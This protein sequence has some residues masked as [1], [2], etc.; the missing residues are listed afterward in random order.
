MKRILCFIITLALITSTATV[1]FAKPAKH[2]DKNNKNYAEDQEFE[3]EDSKVIK[4]GR[5]LLPIDPIVKGMGA[6]VTFDKNTA[7]LTVKKDTTTLIIDFKNKKVT[8]NG[9]E[10]T[11]SGIFTAKNSKKRIVLIKYIAKA[12]GVRVKVD[13]DKVKI[14]VP[15]VEVPALEAPKN[16]KITPIGENVVANT[17]NSTTW[18]FNVTADIKAGQATGGKAELYVNSKLVASTAVAT[19]TGS[20]ISFTTSDGTPTNEE[21]RALVP[22]GGDVTIKLY[23]AENKVVQSTASTKLT[24][25]YVAPTLTSVTSAI[26]QETTGELYLVTVGAGN[27]G[28]AVDVTKLTLY[29]AALAKS[30]QLTNGEKGSKATIKSATSLVITLGEMDRLGIKGFGA[31]TLTLSISAGSLISDK[32]GNVSTPIVT[33]ITLP[34]IAIR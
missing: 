31:T 9:V 32:A 21:L 13:D 20:A 4:Y 30:Y 28:D 6:T 18:Y 26:Y 11:K 19:A 15:E 8:L 3:D 7:V 14:E 33:P 22:V 25:D 10:D 1:A 17:L 34:V 24:V 12:L 16:I 23:N 27:I 2:Q 5:Y 29:D